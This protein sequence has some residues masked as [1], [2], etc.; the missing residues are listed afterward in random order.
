VQDKARHLATLYLNDLADVLRE[1]ADPRFEFVRYAE[2]LAMAQPTFDPLAAALAAPPT[3][4][5]ETLQR[6]TLDTL[7]RHQ[8]QV[9]LLSV[10]FPGSVYAAFRIAQTIKAHDPAIVTVL[11]GGFVTELRELTE[12]RVFDYFDYVT[13]DDGERPLL[14]LLEHLAGKRGNRAWC[15]PTCAKATA[16]CATS[17]SPSPT[18]PSPRSAR[19]PGTACRWTLPVDPRHAQPHAPAVVRRALEQAHRGPRLLLEEVQLLRR[20]PRLHRPLRRRQRRAAGRPHRGHRRRDRP[21]RLPLRRRSRPAQDAQ[22]AGRRA[23]RR[24]RAISWWGNIRF[25]KSFTPSCASS[26][27]T[28][29]ASPSPAAWRWPPTACSS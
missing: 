22:G 13:L 8:P 20:E 16:P 2:S 21:D 15:A 11:G 26:S 3:L 29:A 4:V 23:A 1:A 27:P 7:A 9:V 25:E 18:S 14:A 19:P 6:L 10:P 28:A 5:D 24:N 17:T 12:P